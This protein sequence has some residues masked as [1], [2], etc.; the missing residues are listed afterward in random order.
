MRELLNALVIGLI[1]Y[2]AADKMLYMIYVINKK[3]KKE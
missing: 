2:W 1:V 3:C